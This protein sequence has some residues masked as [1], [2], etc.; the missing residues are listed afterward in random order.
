[1]L[2]SNFAFQ[3]SL[4]ANMIMGII[5]LK[6][7]YDLYKYVSVVMIMMGIVLCTIMSA[8]D[9][10]RKIQPRSKLILFVVVLFRKLHRTRIKSLRRRPQAD[11]HYYFGLLVIISRRSKLARMFNVVGF[12]QEL[13]C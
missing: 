3:G 12:F 4:I 6:K 10:V 13:P 7:S 5:I 8:K 1:M 11:V 2:D 9:A